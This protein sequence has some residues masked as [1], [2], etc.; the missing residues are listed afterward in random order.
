MT[1]INQ[2]FEHQKIPEMLKTGLL[3]LIYKNK[4]DRK[5]SKNYRGITVLP[6]LLRLLNIS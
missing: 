5:D 1:L 4:G 2:I 6:I 3:T